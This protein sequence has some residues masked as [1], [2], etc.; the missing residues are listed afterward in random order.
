[1]D[2][3]LFL[4]FVFFSVA[5]TF[6]YKRGYNKG[7]EEGVSTPIKDAVAVAMA[8]LEQEGIIERYIDD[9]GNEA[10]RGLP[11]TKEKK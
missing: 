6:T 10:V 11:D 3:Q 9:D 5:I 7:Y 4:M 1:M 8:A 2:I